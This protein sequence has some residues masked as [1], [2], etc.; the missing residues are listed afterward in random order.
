MSREPLAEITG[1]K[2]PRALL[3]EAVRFNRQ[4][5]RQPFLGDDLVVDLGYDFPAFWADAGK[6]R[7][8]RTRVEHDKDGNRVKGPSRTRS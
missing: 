6:D 5:L 2:V 4:S 7:P 3:H 1:G 8:V